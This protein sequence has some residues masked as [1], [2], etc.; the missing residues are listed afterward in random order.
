MQTLLIIMTHP[1][2]G[3]FTP[4]RGSQ[5][6]HKYLARFPKTDWNRKLTST[7]LSRPSL[8]NYTE[9]A[10]YLRHTTAS[11]I[12]RKL[13]FVPAPRWDPVI[14]LTDLTP[15]SETEGGA[16][17]VR[18]PRFGCWGIKSGWEPGHPGP[19]FPQH[20]ASGVNP[21]WPAMLLPTVRK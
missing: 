11:L 7:A 13:G 1:Q 8:R 14:L 19:P 21:G 10:G 5:G 15:G 12:G 6:V 2:I 9:V 17:L 20:P 4:V 16:V 18:W 3:V